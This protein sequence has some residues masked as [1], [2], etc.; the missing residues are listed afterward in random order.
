MVEMVETAYKTVKELGNNLFLLE[1]KDKVILFNSNTL[2]KIFTTKDKLKRV[3][4]Q[5]RDELCRPSVTFVPPHLTKVRVEVTHRCNLRCDYCLVYNNRIDMLDESMSLKT[6]RKITHFVNSKIRSGSFMITGGEPLMNKKVTE[7]FIRNIAQRVSVYTNGTL[8]NEEIA[9]LFAQ[10]NVKAYISIDGRR[11]ENVQRKF[12]NGE[13]TY[14]KAIRGYNMLRNKG[15][16]V[17][18]CCLATNRN[19]ETLDVVAR[20]FMEELKPNNIGISIPHHTELIKVDLNIQKYTEKMIRIFHIAKKYGTYVYQIAKRLE[21]LVTQR[22]RFVGCKI[23]GEQ[24]TFYPDGTPTLC[25][26][27]DTLPFSNEITV[28]YLQK[29]LPVNNHYC[30]S[31]FA[32]G[33]C[34]GGC[35]WDGIT[36][37]KEGI[38]KRECYFN[39]CL[40]ETFLWDMYDIAVT[41]GNSPKSFLQAYGNILSDGYGGENE[42]E[43][44]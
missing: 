4:T 22:F 12:V 6:A 41:K 35:F 33:I 14:E 10:Y 9:E 2:K 43:S 23:A 37:Y 34:G 21:P 15:C 39:N 32:K 26:K 7:Y 3:M 13:E 28:D 20:F 8:V 36:L 40:L 19:I 30:R 27:L 38:D 18:I 11:C 5:H 42:A 31:C 17:G 29:R 16:H 24:T 1:D 44:K 25:T